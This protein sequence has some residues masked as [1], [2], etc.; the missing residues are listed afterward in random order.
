MSVILSIA[1]TAVVGLLWGSEFEWRLHRYMH[2]AHPRVAFLFVGHV[3]HHRLFAGKDSYRLHED[4]QRRVRMIGAMIWNGIVLV[5]VVMLPFAAAALTASHFCWDSEAIAITA[6]G[7]ALSVVFYCATE[8]VHWC[9]HAPET[10]LPKGEWF[11]W[12][13]KHHELHH[14]SPLHGNYNVVV[15]L[16]DWWHDTLIRV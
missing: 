6:T 2:Q 15:P 9:A 10:K 14:R 5:A 1:L 3:N 11:R 12:L 13:N 4:D 7:L 16:A 8:Y